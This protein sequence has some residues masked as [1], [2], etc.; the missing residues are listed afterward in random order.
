MLRQVACRERS[1]ILLKA[2]TLRLT[3]QQQKIARN[4]FLRLTELGEGVQDTRR[5]AT[6]D[7]LV[8]RTEDRASVE[9]VLNLLAKARLVTLGEGSVEVAHEALIREW[10]T[11][12][13]W[14][15]EDRDGLRLHRHL[16]EVCTELGRA[17][18][19]AGRA[20]SWGPACPGY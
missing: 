14:L 6:P 5:R 2:C 19:R 20:V 18:L 1:P 9:E 10:P 4:I 17:G 13:A 8:L 16:T 3:P 12:R 11:L 15:S 7:E